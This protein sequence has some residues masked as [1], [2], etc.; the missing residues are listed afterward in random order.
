MKGHQ[1]YLKLGISPLGHHFLCWV[2]NIN[3]SLYIHNFPIKQ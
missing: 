2:T 3:K 1:M